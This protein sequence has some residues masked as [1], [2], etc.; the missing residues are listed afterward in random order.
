MPQLRIALA[1]GDILEPHRAVIVARAA[2][3]QVEVDPDDV[4]GIGGN[5]AVLAQSIIVC[6]LGLEPKVRER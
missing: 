5:R 6:C 2:Q 4:A 3:S 1:V